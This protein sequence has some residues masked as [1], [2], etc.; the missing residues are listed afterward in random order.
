MAI[1]EF[2]PAVWSETLYKSLDKEYIAVNNSSREF[3]GDIRSKGDTVVINGVSG[4]EVFDYEKNADFEKTLQTL[5]T[6]SRTLLISQSKAF[7]FQIDDIDR[8]QKNPALMKQ[9]MREA[10]SALADAA[11]RYVYGLY[12]EVSQSGVITGS[13]VTSGDILDL[14]LA[15]REK[16]MVNN[17]PGGAETTLEV[18]PA[19]AAK[20][21]KAKILQASDNS[22]PM[23]KGCLGSL[24]GFRLYVSN[25][26]A[27]KTDGEGKLYHKC[28]ARTNRAVAFAEQINSVEAYRPEKRFA[29]ALKG[30]HLYGAKI[31]YPDELVLL[32]VNVA[33]SE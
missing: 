1:T 15:V 23:A 26:I 27:S 22:E 8:A 16:L 32:D 4:V 11:D 13:G 2:I 17:V 30:L 3:E 21:L 24:L 20:I 33:E 28:F 5:D 25:N 29:D 18:P 12:T 6:A 31:I 10:A 19:L 7:N 9:A 14:L